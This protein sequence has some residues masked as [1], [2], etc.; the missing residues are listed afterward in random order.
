[1]IKETVDEGL[2]T[3]ESQSQCKIATCR[4]KEFADFIESLTEEDLEDFMDLLGEKDCIAYVRCGTYDEVANECSEYLGIE[5]EQW[6]ENKI[7]DEELD[8]NFTFDVQVALQF[9]NGALFSR[10]VKGNNFGDNYVTWANGGYEDYT[11]GDWFEDHLDIEGLLDELC[12]SY[13]IMKK[14]NGRDEKIDDILSD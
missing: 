9:L 12:N 8:A 13:I 6:F 7:D 5:I 11:F 10:H 2:V 14:A 3:P 1:M 4:K